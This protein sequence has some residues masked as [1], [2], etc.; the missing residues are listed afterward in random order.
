MPVREN[1][2]HLHV[3]ACFSLLSLR[4]AGTKHLCGITANYK[5]VY[6]RQTWQTHTTL[7]FLFPHQYSPLILL[8]AL[9]IS[10]MRDAIK[11]PERVQCC[12]KERNIS[13]PHLKPPKCILQTDT[14][15]H[16][17]QLLYLK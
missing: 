17:N 6:I 2:P 14:Y 15:T 8:E 12:G 3:T 11:R 7:P 9:K 1:N 10:E 13:H 16:G 4:H 5:S